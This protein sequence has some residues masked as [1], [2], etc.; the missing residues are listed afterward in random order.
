MLNA[1]ENRPLS[2]GEKR[3][4][5][6]MP[7]WA[8]R[9]EWAKAVE[10]IKTAL[11]SEPGSSLMW[12][13]FGIVLAQAGRGVEAVEALSE[14]VRLAPREIKSWTILGGILRGQRLFK[15]AIQ[16]HQ[17]AQ[18]LDPAAPSGAANLAATLQAAGD[19]SAAVEWYQKALEL[20]PEWHEV[21]AELGHCL[22][23]LER[24]RE[25]VPLLMNVAKARPD[26]QLDLAKLATALR[27]ANRPGEAVELAE[28]LVRQSPQ[29]YAFRLL[30]GACLSRVGRSVEAMEQYEHAQR[31]NPSELEAFQ[32]MVYVAN[33]LPHKSP[34]DLYRY[35]EQY[36]EVFEKP[37]AA[38]KVPIPPRE[39]RGK[40]RVGYVSG[41]LCR[42]PVASF[43]EPVFDHYDRSAFEVFCYY[44]C[45]KP[46]V[47]TQRLKALVDHWRDVPGVP[48]EALAA[49]IRED[50][51]DIL[52]DLA[53]HTRW[54]RPLVFARKPAPVQVTM[55]GCMQTTGLKAIDYRITD[56]EL[57]PPGLTEA[58]NSEALIRMKCGA[59]C[60]KPEP[61]SPE[62]KPLPVTESGVFTFGS[63]N[64]LAKITPDVLDLWSEVLRRV[65]S[66]RMLLVADSADYLLNNLELR[67]ISRARIEV[68]PRMLERE[69]LESHHRV[70]LILDTFPFNGL[71]V[72]VNALWMG[73]PCV[74]LRGNTS[75]SRAG[76]LLL[77]RLGLGCLV[78]STTQ[79]YV[80]IAAQNA[81][82]P[83]FLIATRATLRE[84]MR[85]TWTDG[86]AYTLELESHFRRML[87]AL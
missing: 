12:Q 66:S 46:D 30:L 81:R 57:D 77:N 45:P 62:V 67:G 78:A 80:E 44:S 39:N 84:K 23:L 7:Q 28:I 22:M 19:Y 65:P 8:S 34:A 61:D 70:D 51:I 14:S 79:E 54:S 27:E 50:R 48:D 83:S 60:F 26:S 4:L 40:I 9:S 16:C 29:M 87:A 49:R 63:Y 25:A 76:S 15:E 6:L 2:E 13:Q 35:Y 31:L 3:I 11:R 38:Q 55:I 59:V 68:L 58:Y 47:V 37:L 75:A 32:I 82:D 41:D 85:A 73:V 5:A 10:A 18:S 42:H 72:S 20:K 43:I 52:V 36:S 86:A 74:T 69:Y 1:P 17:N 56:A 21:M 71:T 24:F 53:G 64:N 33:Y